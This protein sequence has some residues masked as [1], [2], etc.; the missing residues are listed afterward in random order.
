MKEKK[1]TGY[2]SAM[3]RLDEWIR[4]GGERLAHGSSR[5]SFLGKV[6]ATAAIAAGTGIA[7]TAQHA[8]AA[9]C[10]MPAGCFGTDLV[11]VCYAPWVVVAAEAGYSGVVLRKGP[12]FSSTPVTYSDGSP[13]IISVGGHFGRCSNRTGSISAGC[14][15]PGPRPNQN[16]FIWGYWQ[17]YRRQGWMPYN[18]GGTTY[19]VGDNGYTGKFCGV[20][21]FDFDCRYA[22]SACPKWTGCGGVDFT[23]TCGVTY[24]P[25]VTVGSDPSEEKYYIR[26][27]PNSIS[28]GWL[29]PGDRIKRWGYMSVG[30]YTWSCVQALCCAYVPANCRG[31]CRSDCLG[32]PISDNSQCYPSVDCPAGSNG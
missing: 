30:G 3:S 17:N 16:G 26:Y 25:V 31:W 11:N 8:E 4:S 15:D 14:P 10:P 20:G 19:A 27:A 12:H 7:G 18:A 6:G 23:T 24:R 2:K 32:S 21:D 22:G 29:V 9:G 1:S 13:V 28:W 5:R